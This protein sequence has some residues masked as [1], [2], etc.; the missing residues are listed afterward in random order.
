M[1]IEIW[2]KIPGADGLY[3]A[4]SLGRVRSN[5]GGYP[6]LLKTSKVKEYVNFGLRMNGARTTMFVAKAVYLAF[7]GPIAEGM[8][9]DHIDNNQA[10]NVPDN[11]TAISKRENLLKSWRKRRATGYR[12]RN[13]YSKE[14]A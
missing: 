4:S 1:S 7:H 14:T 6:R 5:F 3:E 9:V 2:K 12:A 8:E 13:Q 10:N 11:L